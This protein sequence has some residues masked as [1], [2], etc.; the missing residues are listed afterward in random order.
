VPEFNNDEVRNEQIN[1]QT[2]QINLFLPTGWTSKKHELDMRAFFLKV[3]S[4]E[5]TSSAMIV[6]SFLLIINGPNTF[7]LERLI[8]YRYSN[9][10]NPNEFE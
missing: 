2:K 9:K 10:L 1:K 5:R 4:I 7:L 6:L 8:K 3:T